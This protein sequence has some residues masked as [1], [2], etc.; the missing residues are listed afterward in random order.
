MMEELISHNTKST[1]PT[2]LKICAIWLFTESLPAPIL[3]HIPRVYINVY[4]ESTD[5]AL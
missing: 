4:K 2:E 1:M 3:E 5:D